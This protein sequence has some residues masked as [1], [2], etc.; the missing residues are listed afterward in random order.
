MNGVGDKAEH[1]Q[2]SQKSKRGNAPRR[3]EKR[4]E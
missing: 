3:D 1:A 4:M 2:E